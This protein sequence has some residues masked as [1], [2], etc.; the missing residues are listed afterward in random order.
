MKEYR[1]DAGRW[2]QDKF[3]SPSR[4]T[5]KKGSVCILDGSSITV[6]DLE[7]DGALVVSTTNALTIKDA[8][9]RALALSNCSIGGVSLADR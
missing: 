3:P 9:V 6:E 7:L 4:V 5:I 1:G 8:K 2:I